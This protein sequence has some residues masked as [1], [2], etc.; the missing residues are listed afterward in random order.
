MI[1]VT[2]LTNNRFNIPGLSGLNINDL[3]ACA[4]VQSKQPH[5]LL[6]LN[7]TEWRHVVF[8][9]LKFYK[10]AFKLLNYRTKTAQNPLYVIPCP[11]NWR[12]N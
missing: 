3:L 9:S 12:T 11:A 2:A 6:C 8:V 7:S 4:A 10:H 5:A 1:T